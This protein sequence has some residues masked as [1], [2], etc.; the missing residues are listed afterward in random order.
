[1]TGSGIDFERLENLFRQ[2]RII[3]GR[4]LSLEWQ[5]YRTMK[6]LYL[7]ESR[8]LEKAFQ[9]ILGEYRPAAFTIPASLF[10]CLRAPSYIREMF[11][12]GE[13]CFMGLVGTCYKNIPR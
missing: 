4:Y 9:G 3:F 13:L 6:S 7:V 12:M 11:E 2:E 8:L 5:L 10:G 1:M